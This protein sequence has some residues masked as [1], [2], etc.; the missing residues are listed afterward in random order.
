MNQC[1]QQGSYL[2]DNQQTTMFSTRFPCLYTILQFPQQKTPPY[3]EPSQQDHPIDDLAH[4][5]VK[6][7][8]NVQCLYLYSSKVPIH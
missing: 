6:G 2:H 4:E 1:Q 5:P 8:Q 7:D 3:Y